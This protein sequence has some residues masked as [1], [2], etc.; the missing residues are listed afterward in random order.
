MGFVAVLDRTTRR[1]ALSEE[2]AGTT[3]MAC[4]RASHAAD[5]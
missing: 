1:N 5:L 4:L 3:V 2:T